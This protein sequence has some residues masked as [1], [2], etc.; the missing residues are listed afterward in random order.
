MEEE[1][2]FYPI[3]GYE[4][5]EISRQGNIYSLPRKNVLE[6]RKISHNQ[7]KGDNKYHVYIREFSGEG[8]RKCYGVAIL[9][10]KNFIP[11]PN[12]HRYVLFKDGDESN[13]HADNLYW[14]KSRYYPKIV[15]A[16]ETP[17][18][19]K[20]EELLPMLNDYTIVEIAKKFNVSIKIINRELENQLSNGHISIKT[21]LDEFSTDLYYKSKGAW[22]LS[23]ERSTFHDNK[24]QILN[25]IKLETLKYKKL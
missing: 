15:E 21:D 25:Q 16:T 3:K 20:D 18:A 2:K 19:L 13:Y 6:R 24:D 23:S 12:N 8:G 5:Y 10:A 9:V 4:D 11:N 22:T 1:E 17:L 7:R 14:S